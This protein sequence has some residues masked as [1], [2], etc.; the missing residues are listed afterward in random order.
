[1]FCR[2]KCGVWGTMSLALVLWAAALARGG[3]RIVSQSADVNLAAGDAAFTLVFDSPPDFRTRDVLGRPA[4]SF[5]YEIAPGTTDINQ[6]PFTNIS[7]VIRG[8]EIG[9]SDLIPVRNGVADGSDPNPAAGGWGTVRG[10]LP[11]VLVGER[12]TFTAPLSVLDAPAGVFSYRVFTTSYGRTTS[13]ASAAV[14]PLPAADWTGG[15][16]LLALLPIVLKKSAAGR[17]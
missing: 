9:D 17:Y 7:A 11:F 10:E 3:I 13:V 4:D 8:D 5:Q 1:M 12:L 16:M 6:L 2:G 14:I 15:T